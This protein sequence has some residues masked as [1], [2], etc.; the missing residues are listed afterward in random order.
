ML[1]VNLILKP[2]ELRINDNRHGGIIMGKREKIT[3]IVSIVC[4]IVPACHGRPCGGSQGLPQG[5]TSLMNYHRQYVYCVT[6][7][8]CVSQIK[9]KTV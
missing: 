7:M 4:P 8:N 2:S 9:L 3:I 1:Q 5:T 6:N